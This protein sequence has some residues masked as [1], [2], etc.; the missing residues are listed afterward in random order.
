MVPPFLLIMNLKRGIFTWMSATPIILA[1][2]LLI[3]ASATFTVSLASAEV[4][5]LNVTPEVAE[6]GDTITIS[7]MASPNEEVWV[8]SS[9]QLALPVSEGTYSQEFNGICFIKGEKTFSV[10]AGNIKNTRVSLSPVFWRTIE[11][12]LDGPKNA[13][14]GSATISASF[15]AKLYG[16]EIDIYGEKDVKVYGEAADGATSVNLN[17]ASSIKRISD[18]SGYFE[19]DVDTGGVPEGEFLITA[20]GLE[21][22]VYLGVPEPTPTPSPSPTPTP[23]PSP[24]P[25]GSDGTQEPTP[26][27]T[28]SP[29]PTLTPT[30][31]PSASPSPSINPTP[32]PTPTMTSTPSP[33]PTLTPQT[34]PIK[35]PRPQ[36]KI[37][38]PSQE[39]K[40]PFR[41]PIP[42]FESAGCI[43]ALIIIVMLK[44][45]RVRRN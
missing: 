3:L 26:T 17:V 37:T 42:G 2:L 30:P 29:S 16:V 24:S 35:S 9:F 34:T 23:T 41:I 15:P 25:D 45:K 27:P 11:Y 33:S 6:P 44:Q 43:A 39:T 32:T 10:T 38:P 22:T 19:L 20:G 31:I 5:E 40:K 21:K 8:S 1:L 4:T 14:D 36:N 7:G 12:P 18:S 28:P 13:T